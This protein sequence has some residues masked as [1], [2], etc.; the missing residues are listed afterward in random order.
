M[1]MMMMIIA[2]VVLVPVPV[3]VLD[4]FELKSAMERLGWLEQGW[5][6]DWMEDGFVT[7]AAALAMET[8]LAVVTLE[9]RGRKCSSRHR[10]ALP[11]S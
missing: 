6:L 4:C 7:V 5:L 3:L 8:A 1:M 10:S 9:T 11:R 2:F